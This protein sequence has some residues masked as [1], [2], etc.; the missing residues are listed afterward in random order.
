[1]NNVFADPLAIP[2]N[3]TVSMEE[4][5]CP[6]MEADLDSGHFRG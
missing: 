5:K 3:P 2:G 4:V 1:M 6:G